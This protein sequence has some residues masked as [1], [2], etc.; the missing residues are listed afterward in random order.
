MAGLEQP[1]G[2]ERDRAGIWARWPEQM[3]QTSTRHSQPG[4][5]G[6]C[7]RGLCRLVGLTWP[8]GLVVFGFSISGLL[9]Y[10]DLPASSLVG[11]P[12]FRWT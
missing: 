7:F 6:P 1:A 4:M 3:S 12:R 8:T 10:S 5:D 2:R 11:V 9:R